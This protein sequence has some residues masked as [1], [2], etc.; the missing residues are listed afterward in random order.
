[1]YQKHVKVQLVSVS[2]PKIEMNILW[3]AQDLYAKWANFLGNT[4]SFVTNLYLQKY[5]CSLSII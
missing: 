4:A 3:Y 5:Q 1:M 2:I